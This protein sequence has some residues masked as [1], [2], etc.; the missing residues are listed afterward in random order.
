MTIFSLAFALALHYFPAVFF[1]VVLSCWFFRKRC[2]SYYMGLL[3]VYMALLLVIAFATVLL[4]LDKGVVA[5][6]EVA[7]QEI[8]LHFLLGGLFIHVVLSYTP[9]FFILYYPVNNI[10]DF[11]DNWNVNENIAANVLKSSIW[12]KLSFL[13]IL[14]MM[15]IAFSAYLPEKYSLLFRLF[16]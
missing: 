4:I 3:L 1:A 10:R 13:F 9:L 11:A 8:G 7:T 12:A 5:I 2:K 6:Q 15:N 16:S 14:F